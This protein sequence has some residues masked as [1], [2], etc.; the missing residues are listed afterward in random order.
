MVVPPRLKVMD[1]AT[2]L[3]GVAP[4]SLS[5]NDP[6]IRV[7][8]ALVKLFQSVGLE[9]GDNVVEIYNLHYLPKIRKIR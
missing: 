3:T 5:Q 8:M 9:R 2:A 1:M 6:T 4:A 7:A